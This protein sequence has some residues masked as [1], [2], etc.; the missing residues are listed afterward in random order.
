MAAIDW[1]DPTKDVPDDKCRWWKNLDD[2]GNCMIGACNARGDGSEAPLGIFDG[3]RYYSVIKEMCAPDD[4][5]GRSPVGSPT[6]VRANNNPDYVPSS[7]VKRAIAGDV[8]T[9]VLSIA[10]S[11]A[12]I[13]RARQGRQGTGLDKRQDVRCPFL[14]Y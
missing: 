1:S 2:S 7:R 6:F 10:E 13:A 8:E 9:L 11:E 14:Y 5:G 12:L 4:A 3:P